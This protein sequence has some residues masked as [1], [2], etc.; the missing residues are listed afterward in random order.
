MENNTHPFVWFWQMY[1]L[2]LIYVG[3]NHQNIHQIQLKFLFQTHFLMKQINA[4]YV[5]HIYGVADALEKKSI[6]IDIIDKR[7]SSR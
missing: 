2:E 7:L 5:V 3:N 4:G 1:S 6:D